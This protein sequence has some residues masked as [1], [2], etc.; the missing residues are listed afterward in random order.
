MTHEAKKDAPVQGELA[1]N[2]ATLPAPTPQRRVV[3]TTDGTSYTVV[4]NTMYPL[5]FRAI[6]ADIHG[7]LT[8][9]V[10]APVATT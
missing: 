8:P 3:I 1:T 2:V 10:M 6:L 4:L 9:Q 7:R 5:E